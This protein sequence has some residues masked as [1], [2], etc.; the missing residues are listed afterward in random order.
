MNNAI[1]VRTRY[2][3][4]IS[5]WEEPF[6]D[7]WQDNADMVR[8]DRDVDYG[9]DPVTWGPTQRTIENYRVF[10]NQR[11]LD[12][13]RQN[14]SV[15]IGLDV[16]SFMVTWQRLWNPSSTEE[17]GGLNVSLLQAWI[18]G[19]S[20]AGT[21]AVVLSNS[22]P[23]ECWDNECSYN[24]KT[25]DNQFANVVVSTSDIGGDEWFV[26]RVLGGGGRGGEDATNLGVEDK[27]LASWLSEHESILY[28]LQ[29]MRK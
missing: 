10:P 26:R 9:T 17:P 14:E 4:D 12:S 28:K 5:W 8:V 22:S 15:V 19:P 7:A 25:T 18:S 29:E 1:E 21:A 27:E 11:A 23:D 2:R 6:W 16:D 13:T 24:I 20:N 3:L